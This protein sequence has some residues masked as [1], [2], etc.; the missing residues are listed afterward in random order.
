M[1][2]PGSFPADPVAIAAVVVRAIDDIDIATDDD[3]MTLLADLLCAAWG[4][5]QAQNQ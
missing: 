1:M 5:P 3:R 2:E 4:T